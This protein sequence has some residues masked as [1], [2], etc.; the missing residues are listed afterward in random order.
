MCGAHTWAPS[1]DN[2]DPT[3]TRTR[4]TAVKGRCLNHLTM[5]PYIRKKRRRP[6][7][8]G[9][10]PPSILSAKEL[11][12]CVR[13]GNRCILFAIVT[14]FP[15]LRA[16]DLLLRCC[17]F[18]RQSL[19]KGKLPPL[20]KARLVSETKSLAAIYEVVPSKL[21]NTQAL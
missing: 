2:G 14:A 8:P 11:N 4:V 13:D 3:G 18:V 21:N 1:Y 10:C 6:N 16:F 12:Y 19:T 5:G 15:L 17:F 20:S 9:G 7:F